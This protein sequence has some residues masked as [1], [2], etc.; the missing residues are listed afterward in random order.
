VNNIAFTS[1]TH[2]YHDN[3]IKY[4]NRPFVNVDE[5]NT[6]LA[7]NINA[8]VRPN[9][10]LYHL[11]DWA[12]RGLDYAIQ[13][14]EMI[15]PDINIVLIVGNHDIHKLKYQSFKN[16]FRDIYDLKE[17]KVNGRRITLCH[18]AM[19]VWNKSHHGAWQIF[20]HSHGSLPDDPNSL[21]FDV[22]VDCHNYKPL[23]FV[24]IE[25]IMARKTW[26]PVDHHIG[27]RE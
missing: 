3:I 22:G 17:V 9:G 24:E 15:R 5:M 25:A 20:G 11:G 19:K 13:F 14:R 18:Y 7:K 2:A 10:I 8:A 23:N 12:F 6:A 4:S 27:D 21:S 1:D 16:L 26:K